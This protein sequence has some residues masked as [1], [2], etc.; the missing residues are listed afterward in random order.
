MTIL[1]QE[2]YVKD[3]KKIRPIVYIGQILKLFMQAAGRW[4]LM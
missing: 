1:T 3:G 2:A 4:S